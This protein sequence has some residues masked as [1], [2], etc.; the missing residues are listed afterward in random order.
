MVA[1]NRDKGSHR[2]PETIHRSEVRPGRC[3]KVNS[4]RRISKNL[5]RFTSQDAVPSDRTQWLRF[6]DWGKLDPFDRAHDYFG[7]GSLFVV[8]AAGHMAGHINLLVR[9]DSRTNWVYLAADSVHGD[10]RLLTGDKEFGRFN[11]D[12]G[13]PC[14]MHDDEELAKNHVQRIRK[15]PAEIEVWFTHD[16]QWR[17]TFT[18]S[19]I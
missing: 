11:D 10:R 8:D 1:D 17:E 18:S 7:D 9:S 15:L 3:S 13:Y 14:C 4:G 6:E 5:N 12:G 16:P 19:S 2:R